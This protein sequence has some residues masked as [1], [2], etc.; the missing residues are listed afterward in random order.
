MRTEIRTT[1]L[2]LALVVMVAAFAIPTTMAGK[3]GKKDADDHS[4]KVK[5]A[6]EGEGKIN[7]TIM[8][9][10][11][12]KFE[13]EAKNKSGVV[14]GELEYRDIGAGIKLHGNV[15][16]LEVNK[17]AKPRTANFSGTASVTNATGVKMLVSYT[18]NV[19]AGKKGV[20]TFNITLN[21]TLPF[22]APYSD[23]DTL[24]KGEIEI[25]P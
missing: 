19:T 17:T 1:A 24:L 21:T 15:T 4:K 10:N 11:V 3:D 9:N 16:T 6:I 18:A 8:P 7:S 22:L 14:K 23:N 12:S 25:D 5:V 2:L 20:G 13:F